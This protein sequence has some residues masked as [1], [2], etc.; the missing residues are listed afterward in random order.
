MQF[1]DSND[2]PKEAILTG[3]VGAAVK[4]MICRYTAWQ[5]RHP[6][7]TFLPRRPAAERAAHKAA[8][9]VGVR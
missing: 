9:A 3:R 4:E 7:W 2:Q 8:T 1:V 6:R 5:V